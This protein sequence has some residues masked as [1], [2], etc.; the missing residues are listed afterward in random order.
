MIFDW[1][2]SVFIIDRI[3]NNFNNKIKSAMSFGDVR[4]KRPLKVAFGTSIS[5]PDKFNRAYGNI[6][7]TYF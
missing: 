2:Q 6:F 1:L 5:N 3:F 7:I 4:F